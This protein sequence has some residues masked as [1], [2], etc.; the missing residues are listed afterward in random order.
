MKAFHT[1]AVPHTDILEGKLTMDVFAAD[2]WEVS[3]NRGS[4]EYRDVDTFF[5]KTYLTQG[6]ENL[7]NIVESRV[8]AKGGDPVVQIQTPFGGGKTHALIAMYHK[9]KSWGVNT[10]VISGTALGS[11]QTLWGL[12]EKQLTGKNA[13]FSGM[14]WMGKE[15]IIEILSENQPV[16]ILMDEIL[17]YATKA[18]AVKVEATNLA[19]LT[20]AF[21][22]DL[23]EAVANLDKACLLITLPS[24]IVEHY[25]EQAERLCGED[26][27]AGS[28]QRGR[29]SN[30]APSFQQR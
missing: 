3:R 12:A 21:I 28:R 16:L 20:I 22:K 6:L 27:Y 26:L 14:S 29:E 9:A 17:E 30:P 4:E 5:R 8:K 11:E 15:G 7:I 10:V 18:A 25:D 13:K 2:L 1:V 19:A 23:T 24:S